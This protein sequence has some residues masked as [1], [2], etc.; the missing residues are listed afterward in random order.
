MEF[1]AVILAAGQGSRA[2]GYKPLWALDERVVIEWI[3]DAASSVCSSIR[4]VGGAYYQNLSAQLSVTRPHVTLLEN[5]L[6]KDGGMFSSVRM[7]LEGVESPVFIHPA[8]IP[9]SGCEVYKTLASAY[10]S[11]THNAEV[12]R[13]FYQGYSGHPILLS[14]D[15]A[16]AICNASPE[17]NLRQVLASCKRSNISVDDEFILCDFDTVL[18]YE[19]LKSRVLQKCKC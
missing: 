2:G 10:L 4:V 8:D 16:L 12:F 18:E 11:K 13:P 14:P 7:G 5:A 15:T 6:W 9:G 3:I 19:A 17:T 1:T